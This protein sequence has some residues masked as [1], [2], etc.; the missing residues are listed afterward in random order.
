MLSA[1]I[2]WVGCKGC[3]CFSYSKL[4]LIQ[5]SNVAD[6]V[7]GPNLEL[8]AVKLD[9]PLY[10]SGYML[11]FYFGQQKVVQAKQAM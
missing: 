2:S 1:C 7:P 6:T 10:L 8:S 3:M 4:K 5:Q 9:C 11:I